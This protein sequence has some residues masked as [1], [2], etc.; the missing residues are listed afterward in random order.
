[1]D[2]IPP[3][4]LVP[5][6]MTPEAASLPTF[7]WASEEVGRRHR[8]GGDPQWIGEPDRPRCSCGQEMT[9]YAQLD[10]ISD[11]FVLA[12]CGMIFVFT[13]FDCFEVKAI[14]QST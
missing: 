4:R 5:E 6:P 14:L 11:Q 12:D 13:C 9:F 8:L 3:F 7:K 10:S 1:M 2:K